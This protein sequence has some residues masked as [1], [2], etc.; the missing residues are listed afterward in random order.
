MNEQDKRAVESM[1]RIGMELE[2]IIASFPKFSKEELAEKSSSVFSASSCTGG[3]VKARGRREAEGS[4]K[5]V[6]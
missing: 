2:T 6:S 3:T 5:A 4:G 1:C